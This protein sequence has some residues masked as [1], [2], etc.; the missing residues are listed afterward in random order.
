MPV[1]RLFLVALF[2]LLSATYLAWSW[3]SILGGFGGDNANYLLMARHFSPYSAESTVAATFTAASFYPPLFPLLLGLTGGGE[4]LLAAHLVTTG[5]LLIA[6]ALFYGWLRQEGIGFTTSVAALITLAT[7]PGIYFQ[8]LSVHSENLFMLCSIAALFFA[9][10]A[11][12][13]KTTRWMAFALISITAAYFTRSAAIAL[14]AAWLVWVWINRMPHRLLFSALAVLPVLAW[15]LSGKS[16][17]NGYLQ[18]LAGGYHS[19]ISLF[20]QIATQSLYLFHGWVVNFGVGFSAYAVGSILLILGLGAV[21]W[22]AWQRQLDGFYIL[23]YLGMAVLWPFPA[24]A[25]RLSLTV[26]PVLLVQAVWMLNQWRLATRD[27]RPWAWAAFALIA[28]PGIPELALNTQ[29]YFSP[30]PEGVSGA[31]RHAEWWYSPTREIAAENITA[32][33]AL[34]SGIRD[35]S[36]IVPE[37]DCI[38]A[39]KPS[40]VAYLSGRIAKAPPGIQSSDQDLQ[41][42]LRAGGCRYVFMMIYTSPS[43]SSPLYPY[44]RMPDRLEIVQPVYLFQDEHENTIVGMLGRI[45]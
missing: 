43:Y 1:A 25:Q 35:L 6:F 39:I 27:I 31:Y 23:F 28:A 24:E 18:Q 29:R 41:E 14:I 13:E 26:L 37:G 22:R 17:S 5:F 45:K 38:Y 42:Q 2:V 15:S 40:I 3:S 9:G 30:L 44:Q 34:E 12:Q 36:N 33:A 32:M 21:L 4:S 11:K 19:P 10:G 20:E 16:Q 8:T 7:I